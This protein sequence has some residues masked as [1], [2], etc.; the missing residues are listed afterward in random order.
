MQHI[1]VGL[2]YCCNGR[3]QQ[4]TQSQ[5]CVI[6]SYDSAPLFFFKILS[7]ISCARELLSGGSL[8]RKDFLESE[9]LRP[10]ELD[11]ILLAV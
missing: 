4:N 2:D 8:Q 1:P 6:I 3:Q 7:L 10:S 9:V 5:C 11:Q